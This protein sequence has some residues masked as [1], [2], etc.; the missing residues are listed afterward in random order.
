MSMPPSPWAPRPGYRR[1]SALPQ[2]SASSGSLPGAGQRYQ[3]HRESHDVDRSRSSAPEGGRQQPKQVA[4]LIPS[5]IPAKVGALVMLT[6]IVLFSLCTLYFFFGLRRDFGPVVLPSFQLALIPLG[7]VLVATM[8]LAGVFWYVRWEPRPPG[9]FTTVTLVV[10]F[11]WGTSVSTLC[12]LVVNGWVARVI[13]EAMGDPDAAGV[14]SAPLV[15]ELTKGL[16][17]LFV[18]LI[19]R[20]TI[21]GTIDG[22][23]YAAF[24]AAGFAFVENILYF[25]QG[26]DYVGRIFVMRGLLSPFAHLTF[27]ACTGVAIG[28]SSRRRSQYAWAWMAP[29][30]LVGAILL[31]AT[32]NGFVATNFGVYL[33]LQFPFYALCAGLVSW[34]R[35]SERRSMRRGIEDYARAGWFSPAEVQMLTTGAGRR[36]GSQWAAARGPQ[37]SVAMN[38]FQ[39]GA[40][41]L[42]QLRQQAVDSHVQGGLSVKESELLDRISS[43]RRSFLGPGR[44][45]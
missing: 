26:W 32:W 44:G 31:H 18:F 4:S 23:V 38:T 45:R 14:I 30:G 15:E 35:W 41:E 39:K 27:T 20:R 17:V 21:N 24:T 10:A 12:S 22:V 6:A 8:L 36:S 19:W 40:A 33:L 7:G 43:A 11:L 1:S 25:V 37:A 2:T 9:L 42:A 5:G 13:T 3:V 28:L 29:V 34:L 16:G